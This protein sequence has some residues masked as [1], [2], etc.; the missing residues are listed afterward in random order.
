MDATEISKNTKLCLDT[1]V[2]TPNIMSNLIDG[3]CLFYMERET[4]DNFLGH[5][6]A[7]IMAYKHVMFANK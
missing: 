5:K 3:E 2:Y 6:R 1:N 4:F 7:D